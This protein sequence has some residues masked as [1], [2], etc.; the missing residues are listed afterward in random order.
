MWLR[1]WGLAQD[2]FGPTP[3]PY[4]PLPSHDEALARLVFSIE[5]H[6]RLITFFAGAGLGKSTVVRR[7]IEETRNPRRRFV[8]VTAPTAGHDLLG[9]LA[10]GL[11]L[12]SAV[13]S[14]R[15]RVWRTLC[16]GLR[17]AAL[18]GRQV[19]F[20]VDGWDRSVGSAPM[21]DLMALLNL[22]GPNRPSASL[23]RVGRGDDDSECDDPWTLA[24]GLE[25]LT[26]SESETYLEARLSSAG[27]RDR[28]LTPRALTRLH[29][30]SEGV[31]RALDQLAGFSLI[32]GATQGLEVVTAD[33]VDGVALRSL[34]GVNAE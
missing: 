7:A 26:R 13:G 12:P 34:V 28:I 31:P 10:D 33:V 30:W 8:L 14:D 5:R 1:H 19:V 21:R 20:V 24:I 27:C 4:I 6:R 25:R 16:H 11:G 18:E 17:A 15:D 29:S 23:V 32:A 9:L 22:A 3:A 2:P